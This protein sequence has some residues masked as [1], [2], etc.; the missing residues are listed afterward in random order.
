MPRSP[1]KTVRSRPAE[2]AGV[3]ATLGG[4]VAAVATQNWLAVATAAAGL[5]P[6]LVTGWRTV[7][8]LRGLRSF[9]LTGRGA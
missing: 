7:G 1:I 6:G 4:L 9:V 8:G 5:I 3:G 2:T